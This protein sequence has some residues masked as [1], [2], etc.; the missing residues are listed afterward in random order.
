[1]LIFTHC[2]EC[3]SVCVQNVPMPSI[4]VKTAPSI[5]VIFWVALRL[6]AQ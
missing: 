4:G 6:A 2:A 3:T 1:L 5:V